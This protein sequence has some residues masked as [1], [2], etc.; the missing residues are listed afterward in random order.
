MRFVTVFMWVL[1][2]ITFTGASATIIDIPDDYPTI[3]AGINAASNG[4]TVLI[5]PGIYYENIDCDG[6]SIMVTSNFIFDS[7]SST[8]EQTIIDGGGIST[9]VSMQNGEAYVRPSRQ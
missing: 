3:Q 2:A 5:Q 6:K 7:D 8:I 1:V 9:T 4:D